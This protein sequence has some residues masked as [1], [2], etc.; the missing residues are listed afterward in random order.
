MKPLCEVCGDRH[1]SWQAHVFQKAGKRE[2]VFKE[3]Q[4]VVLEATRAKTVAGHCG[5]GKR[6][7]SGSGEASRQEYNE[8]MKDYMRFWRAI[9][10]GRACHWP[11]RV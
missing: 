6:A 7:R 4:K 10:S 3:V 8:S 11:R 5:S 1:E 2:E 9:R